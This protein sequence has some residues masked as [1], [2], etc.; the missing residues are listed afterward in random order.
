MNLIRVKT[1]ETEGDELKETS[2]FFDKS[3][4]AGFIA[5]TFAREFGTTLLMVYSLLGIL[6]PMNLVSNIPVIIPQ[7]HTSFLKHKFRKP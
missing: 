6:V 1:F 7:E 3:N 4:T 2:P 5:N